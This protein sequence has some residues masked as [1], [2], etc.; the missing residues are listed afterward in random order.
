VV[1]FWAPKALLGWEKRPPLAPAPVFPNKLV[2][3]PVAAPNPKAVLVAVAAGWVNVLEPNSPP[4]R[5]GA[6]VTAGRH[7]A[8]GLRREADSP[9]LLCAGPNSPPVL[10][11]A[12]NADVPKPPVAPKAASAGHVR[13]DTDRRVKSPAATRRTHTGTGSARVDK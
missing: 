11:V 7:A 1:G 9:G 5:G 3:V 6:V 2:A 12:P 10:A 13:R 4:E 8:V